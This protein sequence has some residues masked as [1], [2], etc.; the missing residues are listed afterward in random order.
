VTFV[1]PDERD[2]GG[3]Y[4]RNFTCRTLYSLLNYIMYQYA[5]PQSVKDRF[6][7]GRVCFHELIVL[8]HNNV[9]VTPTYYDAI[10]LNSTR[11]DLFPKARIPINFTVLCFKHGPRVSS[12]AL[13]HRRLEGGVEQEASCSVVVIH[14][15]TFRQLLY[16]IHK[17]VNRV[18]AFHSNTDSVVI[19]EDLLD[20]TAHLVTQETY[21][22]R[23]FD[24]DARL[25]V[26]FIQRSP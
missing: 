26:E 11:L 21:G 15:Q 1:F 19:F 14:H 9:R 16:S 3:V 12:V 17:Q 18:A 8:D 23:I 10:L 4:D 20:E 25:S 22:T 5:W 6:P 2:V 13:T 7:G 24:P